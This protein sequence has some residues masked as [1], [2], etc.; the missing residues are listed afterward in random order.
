MPP[1]VSERRQLLPDD[2]VAA[3]STDASFLHVGTVEGL[4]AH[5]YSQHLPA[6]PTG[7]DDTAPAHDD[8]T[9]T[10]YDEQGVRLQPL[11]SAELAVV[12]F[13]APE[14]TAAEPDLVLSLLARALDLAQ[15]RLD[16][17]PEL[18]KQQSLP[19][20]TLV[21]RPEGALAEVLADLRREFDIHTGPSHRAGWFHNL[22]HV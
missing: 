14:D 18:G 16:E 2:L 12:G 7:G 17:H 3:I 10:F 5:A 4:L 13:E 22:F 21:P 19:A 9:V 6:A 1:N 20:A 15:Q 8:R 11:V